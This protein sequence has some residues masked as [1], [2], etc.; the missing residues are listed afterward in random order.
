MQ[1]AHPGSHPSSLNGDQHKHGNL[2][3][4]DIL[5]NSE[6]FLIYLDVSWGKEE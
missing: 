4:W 1:L 3:G 6:I 5:L 2:Y